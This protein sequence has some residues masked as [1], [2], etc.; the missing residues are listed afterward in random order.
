[1]KRSNLKKMSASQLVVLVGNGSINYREEL[2]IQA[3]IEDIRAIGRI[4]EPVHVRADDNVVLRGNRRTL[5]AQTMLKEPNLPADLR[6][7]LENMDVFVVSELTEKEQTEY[8]LDQGGQKP[9]SRVETIKAVWRLQRQMYSEKDIIRLLYQQLALHTGNTRKAHEAQQIPPGEA[10][11]KFLTTWLHGSVGNIMMAVGRMG[12]RVRRQYILMETA[13]DR[14]LTESELAEIQFKPANKRINELVSAQKADKESTGW[15]P[16]TGGEKFNELI[17]KFIK[18]DKE[19]KP[20]RETRYTPEQMEQ[21]ADSMQ[22]GMRLAFLKCAGK[23]PAGESSKLEALDTEMYRRDK[24]FAMLSARRDSITDTEVATLISTIV[25]GT[26]DQVAEAL[27]PFR[28]KSESN[29]QTPAK[30]TQVA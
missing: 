4:L 3:M 23:L 20:D 27:K 7:A 30:E 25:S 9:L 5:A 18:E 15:S 14:S 17:E 12:D 24:V 19:P 28:V 22:S 1:M 21:T 11:D 13:K 8:I 2:D 16:E 26:A 6:K 10:R 29:G